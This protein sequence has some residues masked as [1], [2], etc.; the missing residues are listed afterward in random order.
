MAQTA[1][2]KGVKE[3]FVA[4]G[5][6]G[7]RTIEYEEVQGIA[8]WINFKMKNKKSLTHL[9]PLTEKGMDIFEKVADGI[10]LCDL[11]NMAVRETIDERAINLAKNGKLTLFEALENLDL[12]LNAASAIGVVVIGMDRESLR[13]GSKKPHLVL[14]LVWQIIEKQLFEGINVHDI[15]GLKNLLWEGEDINSLLRLS[16]TEILLRWVNHQLEKKGVPERINNFKGDIKDSTA[17]IHLIDAIAPSSKGVTTDGLGIKDLN[18]RANS[19]L[20]EAEKIGCKQFVAA[21][22]V[23]KGREKLNIAFTANLLNNYPNLDPPE[24]EEEIVETREEKMYRNWMNSL[25]VSPKVKWLYTD[26]DNGLILFQLMDFIKPGIVDW[27]RVVKKFDHIEAKAKLEQMGNSSYAVELG[28]KMG[29][30]LPGTGGKDIYDRI[31]IL[32]LGFVWQLMR[33]YT[34][35][36]LKRLNPN[37]KKTNREVEADTIKWANETLA[38]KGKSSEISGFKDKSLATSLPVLDLIDAVKPGSINTNHVIMD[39]KTED[40]R[41]SN[42][43]LAVSMARKIGAPIYALPEDL[44]EGKHQMIMT[45]FVCIRLIANKRF[46]QQ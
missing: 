42:A 7:H 5:M 35:S 32:V 37:E 21:N 20:D 29:L 18:D 41:L 34:I 12:A 19:M 46:S 40:E 30:Q 43:R 33:E 8:G 11:I 15:P 9:L 44:V 39:P 45:I 17:Y 38:S 10:L 2:A 28:K 23:V 6:V 14:G 13:E 25:G 1:L 3:G 31:K 22:D 26:L 27:K 36:L 16:P 24:V 4:E